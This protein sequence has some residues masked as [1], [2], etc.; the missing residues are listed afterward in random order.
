MKTTVERELTLLCSSFFLV[1]LIVPQVHGR[2]HPR[3]ARG[4]QPLNRGRFGHLCCSK[5]SLWLRGP[6]RVEWGVR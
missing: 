4:W 2:N 6:G 1:P 3:V 5:A